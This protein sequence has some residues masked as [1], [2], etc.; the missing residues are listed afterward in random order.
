MPELPDQRPQKPSDIPIDKEKLMIEAVQKLANA[1]INVAPNPKY[2]P[3]LPT[4]VIVG[5]YVRDLQ[6]G[7]KPKDADVEVY[8]VAPDD[9]DK[10]LLTTFGKT[11]DV[12]ETF[13][14]V[15]VPLGNGTELDVSIPRRES[16][17]GKGHKGFLMSSDP[18][19]NVKEAARRRDFTVNAMAMDPFT[20]EITDPFGGLEDIKTKTLRVT[21]PER[22]QDDPL[23]VLRA[24]QFMAR[25]GFSVEAESEKLM[26]EMVA[27]GDMAEL[28]IE[29]ITEEFEKFLF[30]GKKP[31]AG[32]LLAKNIGLIEAIFPGAKIEDW[33]R[34]ASELDMVV[35]GSK[36]R[37]AVM[38]V[39][40]G[41][42]TADTRK[43]V[44]SILTFNKKDLEKGLA[45]VAQRNRLILPTNPVNDA[46]ITLKH[47]LPSDHESYAA[48]LIAIDRALEA[49]NFLQLVKD[50]Q[51]NT[52]PILEGR[53]FIK[54]LGLKPGPQ[55]SELIKAVE[56]ARDLAQIETREQALDL[57]KSILAK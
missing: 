13:G 17:V 8:G 44:A 36:T 9:L 32:L 40:L 43:Q 19:L 50:Y 25:L 2:A 21:D 1:I 24:V 42:F 35:G 34:W 27:R 28:F 55:F 54:E 51:L 10:I 12:G 41:G 6:L 48:Y 47:I 7:L 16:K 3:Q 30:K 20:G 49:E 26:H 53:D 46:R 14:I 18:S 31:S 39:F 56:A 45:L 5:G 37:P 23:R 15:K 11:K 52:R 57:V 33:D 4:V 38:A 22:F 29:R